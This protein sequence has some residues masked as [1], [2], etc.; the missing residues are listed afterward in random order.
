M[1]TTR[2]E[3]S[4][5]LLGPG[6]SPVSDYGSCDDT[7]G[8][9]CPA[10]SESA[11]S[12]EDLSHKPESDQG[13]AAHKKR[14]KFNCRQ[15]MFL[16][17]LA[18][19]TMTSSLSLCIFPPFFPK[20]AESKG[21]SASVYGAIIGTN[22]LV[23]FVVTPFLGRHIETIGVGFSLVSGVCASGVSCILCGMLEMF[24]A[25]MSF[26]YAAVAIRTVQSIGNAGIIITTFTYTNLQFPRSTGI[27]FAMNRT[28]MSV[29]QM[30]GPGLGGIFYEL[31]GF[32]MPFVVFGV[33]H[34]VT[35]MPLV[36]V[37]PDRP[38]AVTPK[39]GSPETPVRRRLSP[40]TER[41]QDPQPLRQ[42]LRIPGIWVAFVSFLVSTLSTG[43]LSIT[44]EA[45]ILRKYELSHISLGMMFGLKDGA[46]SITSPIWGLLCDKFRCVKAY[47]VVT[48]LTAAVCFA[49]F[50]PL[51]GVPIHQ[52]L[53]LLITALSLYGVAIGGMQVSGMVDALREATGNGM[54]DDPTTHGVVAGMWSSLSGAGRF[55]SRCGAGILV[56]TIGFPRASCVVVTLHALMAGLASGYICLFG[57]NQRRGR[58]EKPRRRR[59]AGA[60]RRSPA[61]SDDTPPPHP[62]GALQVPLV[63][64]RARYT[65]EGRIT[66]LTHSL[67]D[68]GGASS[69]NALMAE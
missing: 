5:R 67:P 28:V 62:S 27:I 50:G 35:L 4:E 14:S 26:V 63:T 57:E 3:E 59:P 10:D 30:F 33:L 38:E 16:G 23:S 48:S 61:S 37:L 19:I 32:Y 12:S 52:T 53:G 41:G 45:Q 24:P 44:L 39:K 36:C 31:G 9:E 54:A 18:S 55:I 60:R 11:N 68:V 47:V 29:A 56:D 42:M 65:S 20:V 2:R 17:T 64:P 34:L 46:S 13:L 7:V 21:F 1:A 8:S 66:Y 40:E 49:V 51:P 22:C 58:S 6:G 43:F 15:L 25:S 69:Y